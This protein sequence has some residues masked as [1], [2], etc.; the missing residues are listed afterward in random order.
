MTVTLSEAHRDVR[1]LAREFAANEIAPRAAEW[2]AAKHVPI[3][4]IR[5][6]GSLG[7]LAPT[8]P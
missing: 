4:V 8:I 1:A 6:M 3:D 5:R 7:L 2:N